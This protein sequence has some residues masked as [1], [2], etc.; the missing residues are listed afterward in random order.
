MKDITKQDLAEEI[1]VYGSE[2]N[3]YRFIEKFRK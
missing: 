1:A 2:F 3:L